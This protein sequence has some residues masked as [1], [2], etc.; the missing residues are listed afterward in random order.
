MTRKIDTPA[1]AL[2]RELREIP[3]LIEQLELEIEQ[4]ESSLLTSQQWS[5]NKVKGGLKQSQDDKYVRIFSITEGAKKE[6]ARLTE[7]R[8]EIREI[9]KQLDAKQ[10][11]VLFYCALN[12]S[13]HKEA[14]LE[15][16]M[17]EGSYFRILRTGTKKLNEVIGSLKE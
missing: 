3:R 13:S 15:R 14:Y 6:I 5:D 9:C 17:T 7:R 10:Y 1:H 12:Y 2:L 16:G 11:D 4:A 8:E